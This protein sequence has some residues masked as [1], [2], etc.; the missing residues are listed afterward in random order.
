LAVLGIL[1]LLGMAIP[2][3][4][5]ARRRLILAGAKDPRERVLAVFDV[6]TQSAADVGLGR[7][8]HETVREYR[9][10]LRDRVAFLNGDLDRLTALTSAA[11]Y[12][13]NPVTGADAGAAMASA[14]R[15][16]GELRRAAGPGRRIV[17][18][19]RLPGRVAQ[20]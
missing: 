8:P 12:S 5:F 20:G 11:A 19:F 1:I 7:L 10:R 17:G 13:T 6:M 4:K 3:V 16:T 18:W 2:W 9:G 15:V 14:R